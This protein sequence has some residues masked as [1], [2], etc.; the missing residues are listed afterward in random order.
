MISKGDGPLFED[1][2]TRLFIRHSP[3]TIAAFANSALNMAKRNGFVMFW[4]PK[5][6][7]FLQM[8]KSVLMRLAHFGMRED[9]VQ[10]THLAIRH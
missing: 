8:K 5:Q 9:V 10:F 7:V 2:G 3:H 1:R 4:A 6:C